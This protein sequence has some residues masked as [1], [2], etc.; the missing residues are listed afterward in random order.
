M[1]KKIDPLNQKQYGARNLSPI[2]LSSMGWWGLHPEYLW[3]I[4]NCSTR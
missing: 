2:G 4:E 3:R 1:A